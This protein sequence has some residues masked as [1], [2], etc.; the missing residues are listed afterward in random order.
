MSA[1]SLRRVTDAALRAWLQDE[2]GLTEYRRVVRENETTIVISKFE[3]G[4]SQDLFATVDLLPELFEDSIVQAEYEAL[5]AAHAARGEDTLRT[6]VWREASQ[7]V[8]NRYAGERGIDARRQMLV[9][10]GIESVQ[11]V[12]DTILWTCPTIGQPFAPSAGEIEAFAEFEAVS[13]REPG[14]AAGRDVFTRFY[15]VMG[16]RRVENYCP[17]APFGRRLVAQAWRICTVDRS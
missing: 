5:A 13:L 15:G 11:A 12:L 10:P 17:G 2:L 7:R 14:S 4:F 3:P 6:E 16:G 1:A 8:L 9:L